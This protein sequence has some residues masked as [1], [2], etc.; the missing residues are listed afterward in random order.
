MAA[1]HARPRDD[2]ATDARQALAELSAACFQ[3]F[4]ALQK[5]QALNGAAPLPHGAA[6]GGA[7]NA[8]LTRLST[9]S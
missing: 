9:P 2:S 1:P 3:A 4:V 6:Q 8:V 7:S 5:R